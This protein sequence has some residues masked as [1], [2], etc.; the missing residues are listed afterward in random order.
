ME[1]TPMLTE[2]VFSFDLLNV[3]ETHPDR[4]GSAATD[5]D[6]IWQQLCAM[7]ARSR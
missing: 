2:V 1:M 4:F 5:R 7:H 6:E 3:G